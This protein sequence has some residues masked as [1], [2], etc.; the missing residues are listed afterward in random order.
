MFTCDMIQADVG[1]FL[2]GLGRKVAPSCL[3]VIL[4]LVDGEDSHSRILGKP[5]ILESAAEQLDA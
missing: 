4:C 2:N 1:L 5:H 3:M